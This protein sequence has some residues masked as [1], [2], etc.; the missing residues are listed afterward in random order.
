MENSTRNP[1]I[2]RILSEWKELKKNKSS[3]LTAHP[4]EDNLFEWHFT[5]RGS[6]GTDFEGGLYH[7]RIL[8]PHNYPM[9]PPNI[10]F[11]TPNGRFEIGMKICLTVSAHHPETWQPSW[12][13]RTVLTAII[14]FMPS[15][16]SGAIG[17]IDYSK[18]VRQNMAKESRG[19]KCN[20]CG[21]TNEEM[22]PKLEEESNSNLSTS[23]TTSVN[24]LLEE[25]SKFPIADIKIDKI[26]TLDDEKKTGEEPKDKK[27]EQEN[28]VSDSNQ[29][30]NNNNVN[31]GGGGGVN[32]PE[33]RIR[34]RRRSQQ[35]GGF[36]DLSIAIIF[37]AIVFLAINKWVVVN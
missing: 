28:H 1:A 21:K 25:Q 18:E 2:R 26:E 31:N 32:A 19:W 6:E 17:S 23:L 5:I 16:G 27:Q 3:T 20:V 9:K 30:N 13:I 36:V 14:G 37:F 12:S 34:Q 4:L 29:N 24:T 33:E 11:L 15:P 7:G 10:V 22:L 35:K 8:L